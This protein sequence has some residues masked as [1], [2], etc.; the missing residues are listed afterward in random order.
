MK[1]PKKPHKSWMENLNLDKLALLGPQWWVVRV[2]RASTQATAELLAKLLV[3]DF[4]EFEFKVFELITF[5][6]QILV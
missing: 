5:E 1:K 6:K 2:S 4:P 3:R